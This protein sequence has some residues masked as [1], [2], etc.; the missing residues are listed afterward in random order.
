MRR[1]DTRSMGEIQAGVLFFDEF[2]LHLLGE[3]E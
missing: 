1:H 2:E 3:I